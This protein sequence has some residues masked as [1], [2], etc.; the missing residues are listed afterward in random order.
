MIQTNKHLMSTS[1]DLIKVVLEEALIAQ[2][3]IDLSQA[4][5]L[6]KNLLILVSK[7]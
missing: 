3:G 1:L 7:V 6:S 5:C 2:V 4:F